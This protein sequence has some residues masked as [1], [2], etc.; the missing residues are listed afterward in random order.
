MP[1]DN[2]NDRAVAGAV[3]AR[4]QAPGW[5]D[6]ASWLSDDLLLAIGWLSPEVERAPEGLLVLGDQSIPVDLRWLAYSRPDVSSTD[7]QVGRIFTLRFRCPEDARKP[8]GSLEVP[9]D[10]R[11]RRL[12]TA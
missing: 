1:R 3:A 12:G 4:Q 10:G 7:D 11:P 2:E 8:L 6:S 9:F 5:V